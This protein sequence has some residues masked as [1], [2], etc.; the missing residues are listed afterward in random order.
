MFW[1]DVLGFYG[2]NLPLDEDNFI[3][4]TIETY[5]YCNKF[6]KFMVFELEAYKFIRGNN[7]H[8]LEAWII[9]NKMEYKLLDVFGSTCSQRTK[10]FDHYNIFH[11]K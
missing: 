8:L 5:E 6:V 3:L 7:S 11:H 2:L 4:L 9:D 1:V 10:V